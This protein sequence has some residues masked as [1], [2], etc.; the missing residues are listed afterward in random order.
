MWTNLKV[1]LT[2]YSLPIVNSPVTLVQCDDDTDG[3]STF[4]RKNNKI[5][6]DFAIMKFTYFKSLAGASSND[7]N[8]LINNPLNYTS[9][10]TVWARVENSNK[11]QYF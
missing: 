11:Y 1:N 8:S 2:V 5:T 6:N 10:S 9:G 7:T 3:I 4:N